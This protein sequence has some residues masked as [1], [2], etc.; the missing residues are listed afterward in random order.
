LVA[1]C[2]P[3]PG[4]GV[5]ERIRA[6]NSPVVREVDYGAPNAIVGVEELLYIYVVDGTTEAQALDMW[7]NVAVPAGIDQLP[8]DE[9]GVW[10]GFKALADGTR[11]EGSRVLAENPACP[12]PTPA[13]SA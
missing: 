6:A 10:S 3:S 1:G 4:A 8:S 9:T 13:P 7:C 5:A 2:S 12:G 11:T